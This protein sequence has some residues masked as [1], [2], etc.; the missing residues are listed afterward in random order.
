MSWHKNGVV[1]SS[2]L[3]LY[4][5]KYISHALLCRYVNLAH[6]IYLWLDDFA[7]TLHRCLPGYC[8]KQSNDTLKVMMHR[9]Y[10]GLLPILIYPFHNRY[11]LLILLLPPFLGIVFQLM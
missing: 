4:D 11:P 2:S 5:S 8:V 9:R 7:S 6:F 3:G 10:G 1:H